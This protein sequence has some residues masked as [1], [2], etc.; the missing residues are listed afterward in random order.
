MRLREG[1]G[2]WIYW[3][4][5][6]PDSTGM[7]ALT[8]SPPPFCCSM[9][10]LIWLFIWILYNKRV[11]TSILLSWVLGGILT[12]FWTW[13]G[14]ANPSACRQPERSVG[15]F[16]CCSVA[17]SCLTLCDHMGV[18]HEI[19]QAKILKW[20][21]LPFSRGSSQPRGQ[22]QVSHIAGGFFTSWAT[23]NVKR[24]PCLWC[25]SSCPSLWWKC[26]F[27]RCL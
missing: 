16:G 21:A 4:G 5:G 26:S 8:L 13:R 20:V 17:P 22:T 6:H 10:L 24:Y 1:P 23:N 14:H 11:I 27:A 9:Y 2:W 19:L 15:L 12:N 25:F 18:V 3:T 7:N